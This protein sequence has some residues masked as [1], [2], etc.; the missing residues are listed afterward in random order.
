MLSLNA[1]DTDRDPLVCPILKGPGHGRVFGTGTAFTYLPGT[2]FVGQDAFTYKAWDGSSYSKEAR[3]TLYVN[4]VPPE[5]VLSFEE[6]H[7]LEDGSIQLSL[8]LIPGKP[9]I[10]EESWDMMEWLEVQKIPGTSSSLLLNIA[11]KKERPIRYFRL[12]IP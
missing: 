9:T 6:I 2:G 3:V 1:T 8:D 5:P 11:A 10:L 7:A 12:R 4:P